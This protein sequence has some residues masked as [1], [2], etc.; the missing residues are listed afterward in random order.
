MWLLTHSFVSSSM[1]IKKRNM[2]VFAAITKQLLAICAGVEGVCCWVSGHVRGWGSERP[3]SWLFGVRCWLFGVR[4]CSTPHP[5]G[6]MMIITATP[7][8]SSHFL[9]HITP[10][11]DSLPYPISHRSQTKCIPHSWYK[12]SSTNPSTNPSILID[13]WLC[14]FVALEVGVVFLPV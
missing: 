7:N 9:P 11:R 13:F 3:R 1:N 6:I 5:R 12:G 8:F 10:P 2:E 14:A 4:C